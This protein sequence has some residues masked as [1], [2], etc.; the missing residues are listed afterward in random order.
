MSP[1]CKLLLP[2]H[3]CARKLI[4]ANAAAIQLQMNEHAVYDAVA[5]VATRPRWRKRYPRR[6]SPSRPPYISG[7]V[8]SALS[9][10]ATVQLVTPES[11]LISCH[12]SPK[13]GFSNLFI[14]LGISETGTVAAYLSPSSVQIFQSMSSYI[15][16]VIC[17]RL[18]LKLRRQNR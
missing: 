9:K 15:H 7:S 16:N 17:L 8:I 4:L 13:C 12:T 18:L 10:L 1:W 14:L 2:R 11:S 6:G 3:Q 5:N